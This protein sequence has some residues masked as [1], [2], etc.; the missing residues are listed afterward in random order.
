MPDVSNSPGRHVDCSA[1]QTFHCVHC[2]RDAVAPCTELGVG[3]DDLYGDFLLQHSIIQ[4]RQFLNFCL[5]VPFRHMLF[6]KYQALGTFSYAL[7]L[8][9]FQVSIP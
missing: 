9:S 7:L 8:N 2:V 3:L 4:G 6:S 1:L 5:A